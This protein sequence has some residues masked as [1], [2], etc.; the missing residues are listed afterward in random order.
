ML[1]VKKLLYICEMLENKDKNIMIST[2]HSKC[3]KLNRGHVNAGWVFVCVSKRTVNGTS[4]ISIPY[5]YHI[6]DPLQQFAITD[7]FGAIYSSVM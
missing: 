1:F 2:M 6:W 3:K 5:T 7:H 4:L